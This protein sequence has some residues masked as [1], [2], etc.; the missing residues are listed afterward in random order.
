MKVIAK[1]T[2][3]DLLIIVGELQG[4]IGR[5]MVASVD[6]NQNR[7]SDVERITREAHTLCVGARR[8]DPPLDGATSPRLEVGDKAKST[9]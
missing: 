9:P 2:R 7:A 3:R 4:C 8:F 1:P 5:I 6:R